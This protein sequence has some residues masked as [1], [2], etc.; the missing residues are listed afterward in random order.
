VPRAAACAMP[1]APRIAASSVMLA[2][3]LRWRAIFTA[4]ALC[5]FTGWSVASKAL[6]SR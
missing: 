6:G 1:A 2:R 3:G 5:L 4:D